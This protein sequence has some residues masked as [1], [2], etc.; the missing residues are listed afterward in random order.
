MLVG[1]QHLDMVECLGANKN[2]VHMAARIHVGQ[3]SYRLKP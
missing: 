1:V 3:V 2:P